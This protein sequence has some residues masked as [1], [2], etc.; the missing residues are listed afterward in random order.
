MAEI[1]IKV[2]GY[3]CERCEHEWIPRNKWRVRAEKA[4]KE[5]KEVKK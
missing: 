4:E 2:R 1:E 5:L 3:K